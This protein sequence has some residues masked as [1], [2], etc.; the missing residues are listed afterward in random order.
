MCFRYI[1]DIL[2]ACLS[3]L[4]KWCLEENLRQAIG[5]ST[6]SYPLHPTNYI[7]VTSISCSC[8]FILLP[9]FCRLHLGMNFCYYIYCYMS[10]H[11]IKRTLYCICIWVE[12]SAYNWDYTKSCIWSSNPKYVNLAILLPII[13]STSLMC[14]SEI[15]ASLFYLMI[16]VAFLHIFQLSP[17]P[18]VIVVIYVVCWCLKLINVQ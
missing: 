7:S 2:D 18:L 13:S 4:K 15:F 16:L 1:G 8:I 12:M 14:N 17:F 3:I 11:G 9:T 5:W 6:N 10:S